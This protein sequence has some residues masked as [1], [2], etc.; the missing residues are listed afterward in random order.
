MDNL[1]T[2]YGIT[3]NLDKPFSISFIDDFVD[4]SYRTFLSRFIGIPRRQDINR[5]YGDAIHTGLKCANEALRDG[6]PCD[7]CP[8]DCKISSENKPKAADKKLEE[9]PLQQ[10]MYKGY[11]STFTE[12]KL[13]EFLAEC[14]TSDDREDLKE[15]IDKLNKIAPNSMNDT[16]F[17]RQPYGKILGVEM[18]L[19][20]SLG[21]FPFC[22][23]LDL[24]ME[25]DAKNLI[26]DYKTRSNRPSL[27]D[28]PLRQF[29]P[30]V[31]MVEVQGITTHGIGAIYLLKSEPPK[32]PRKNSPPFQYAIP[33]WMNLSENQEVIQRTYDLL[34]ED[35]TMIRRCIE[36]G[37]F[38]RNRGSIYCPCEVADYCEN[39]RNLESYISKYGVKQNVSRSQVPIQ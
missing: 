21:S 23:K 31:K 15:L 33:H 24:L 35:M 19:T 25:K 4:C 18:W 20:G 8:N 30:Y 3:P 9:C 27:S 10:I 39:T 6:S 29:L 26:I 38:L 14:R 28:F 13:N 32:R 22:G 12:E 16:L 34:I 2:K 1:L 5:L 11:V 17:R 37:I 7:I 36:N